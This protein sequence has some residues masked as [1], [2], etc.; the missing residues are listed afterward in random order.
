MHL[1]PKIRASR[2][3]KL[4]IA[5]RRLLRED[6]DFVKRISRA[7]TGKR[8]TPE[9]RQKISDYLKSIGHHPKIRGGNGTGPTNP[10]KAL[11]KLFPEGVWNF[12]IKTGKW[13]GSSYPPVYKSDFAFPKIKLSIEADG[14]THNSP[15]R[16]AM[17]AK[18]DAFLLGLGWT[19]LRFKNSQIM[20]H[21]ETTKATIQFTISKLTNTQVTA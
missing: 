21:P 4:S 16:R 12:S 20:D 17:D 10:E 6:P 18:K 15:K 9:Q 7:N 2:S 13:N 1:D 8:R 5:R 14:G 19:T 3:K 11:I